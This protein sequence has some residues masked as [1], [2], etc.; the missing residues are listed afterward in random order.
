MS[1][2]AGGVSNIP[3]LPTL[4][5]TPVLQV[6]LFP[7]LQSL[8]FSTLDPP[9]IDRDARRRRPLKANIRVVP[10]YKYQ[11]SLCREGTGRLLYC[12]VL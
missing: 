1:L 11:R 12:V 7:F 3:S 4:P 6:I 9:T 10:G 8:P 2:C 5:I